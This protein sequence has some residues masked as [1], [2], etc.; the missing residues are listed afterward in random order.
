MAFLSL[1]FLILSCVIH[2]T[3]CHLSLTS[4]KDHVDV[5]IPLEDMGPL[6]PWSAAR[7][8]VISSLQDS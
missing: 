6:G 3:L 5:H 1:I 2:R 7:F 8:W 4:A